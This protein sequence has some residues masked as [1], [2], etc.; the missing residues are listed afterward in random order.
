MNRTDSKYFI[1]YFK[2]SRNEYIKLDNGKRVNLREVVVSQDKVTLTFTYS[3]KDLVL[4]FELSGGCITIYI[5]DGLQGSFASPIVKF[6]SF[7][8]LGKGIEKILT[9][10]TERKDEVL[11]LNWED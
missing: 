9:N 3:G 8:S 6:N 4:P 11:E 2:K 5:P 1:D 7:K 10:W